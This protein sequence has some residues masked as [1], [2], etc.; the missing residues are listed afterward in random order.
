MSRSRRERLIAAA[1]IVGVWYFVAVLQATQRYLRGRELEPNPWV[2]WSALGASLAL[3]FC[4]LPGCR[5]SPA[6]AECCGYGCDC[7]C[8]AVCSC[9]LTNRCHCH[10]PS[11]N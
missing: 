3:V 7:R 4:A 5:H 11:A 8:G 10:T 9:V 2:F 6:R 1:W